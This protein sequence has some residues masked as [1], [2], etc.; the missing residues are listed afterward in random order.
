MQ[1]FIDPI[2]PN[3]ERQVHPWNI[4]DRRYSAEFS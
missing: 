3:V 1:Q 4:Y 2:L